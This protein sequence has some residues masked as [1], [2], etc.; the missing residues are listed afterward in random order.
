MNNTSHYEAPYSDNSS[1]SS[2]SERK[3]KMSRNSS[4]CIVT[5][6]SL[7][8]RKSKSKSLCTRLLSTPSASAGSSAEGAPLVRRGRFIICSEGGP[9]STNFPFLSSWR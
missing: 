3:S 8:S 4:S 2:V 9:T 7:S 6:P 5:R 1:D